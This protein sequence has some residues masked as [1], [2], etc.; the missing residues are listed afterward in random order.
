MRFSL[1][2]SVLGLG[3][4]SLLLGNVVSGL[5]PSVSVGV[6][7]VATNS[8]FPDL[9]EASL[10]ELQDGLQKGLFTSVDLVKV[11]IGNDIPFEILPRDLIL[12][13]FASLGAWNL[14]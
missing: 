14:N 8:K 3:L 12:L 11:R 4:G 10:V 1:F 9:Y 6:E 2:S 13:C 7:D 5:V